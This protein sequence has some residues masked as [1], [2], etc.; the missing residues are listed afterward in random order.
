MI[1]TCIDDDY[2]GEHQ[3]EV[4]KAILKVGDDFL[5]P[6]KGNK[7]EVIGYADLDGVE[8]YE[9]AEIDT[10]KHGYNRKLVFNKSRF[11]ISDDTFIPNAVLKGEDNLGGSGLC[12]KVNFYLDFNYKNI[13]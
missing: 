4:V 12:R 3:P 13:R 1:V 11:I 7:Y 6:K 8:A 2:S 5:L 10:I 9:L